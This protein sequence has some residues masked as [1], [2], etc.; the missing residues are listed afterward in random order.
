MNEVIN[1]V[2]EPTFMENPIV[3]LLTSIVLLV[4]L[5]KGV[6]W[7]TKYLLNSTNEKPR[8]LK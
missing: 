8:D 6:I 2:E 1:K 5:V 7:L 3:I 4:V